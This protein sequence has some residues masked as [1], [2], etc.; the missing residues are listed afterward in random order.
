MSISDESAL[1]DS[2]LH[3]P[4]G[5]RMEGKEDPLWQRIQ[6]KASS[7]LRLFSSNFSCPTSLDVHSLVQQPLEEGGHADSGD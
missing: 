3:S 6:K 5:E 7:L 1:M 4:G 2:G